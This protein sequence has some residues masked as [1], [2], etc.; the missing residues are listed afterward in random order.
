MSVDKGFH[1]R[2]AAVA[3]LKIVLI[4]D[5]IELVVPREVLFNTGKSHQITR[6]GKLK[7]RRRNFRKSILPCD[8]YKLIRCDFFGSVIFD[9]TLRN[10]SNNYFH[11]LNSARE[12][13]EVGEIEINTVDP[14]EK[15]LMKITRVIS[16]FRRR[17]KF[18]CKLYTL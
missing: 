17:I 13:K 15:V 16:N 12:I 2:H 14:N 7:F 3:Q 10:F 8:F 18:F 5:F 1:I 4:K 9:I 6:V 11:F